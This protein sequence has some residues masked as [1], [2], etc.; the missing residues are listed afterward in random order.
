MEGLDEK[1]AKTFNELM[2]LATKKTQLD[3]NLFHLQLS[4]GWLEVHSVAVILTGGLVV[5][6]LVSVL[7]FGGL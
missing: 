1:D 5:L 2:A 4:A 3:L 6:H 7:Y